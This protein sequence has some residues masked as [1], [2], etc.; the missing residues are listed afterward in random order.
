MT[1]ISVAGASGQERP[2]RRV[3]AL[4][5]PDPM[6]RRKT[7]CVTFLGAENS[8]VSPWKAS[9]FMARAVAVIVCPT[10]TVVAGVKVKLA[11]P[12]ASVLT[13]GFCPMHFLPSFVPEGLK[14]NWIV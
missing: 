3:G 9:R 1:P 11:L 6:I 10:G 2:L 13:I 7:P 12:D 5:S 8:E 4:I 14:K